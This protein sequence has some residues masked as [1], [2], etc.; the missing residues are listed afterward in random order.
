MQSFWT[1]NFLAVVDISCSFYIPPPTIAKN[2]TTRLA[3]LIANENIL[4][5]LQINI[6]NMTIKRMSDHCWCK[7][8]MKKESFRLR[9]CDKK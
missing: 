1:V 2:C 4:L 9:N 7:M 5:Q 8:L 3:L 6:T